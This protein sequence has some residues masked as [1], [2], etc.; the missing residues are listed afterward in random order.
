MTSAK[1]VQK[2][3]HSAFAVSIVS[4]LP[5]I[6]CCLLPTVAALLTL[7]TTV[8]LGAALANDRLY[9]FV[10]GYHVYIL[11]LAVF[12]VVISGVVNLAASRIEIHDHGA[13][14]GH[15]HDA[16]WFDRFS[17]LKIFLLSLGLLAFDVGY[18]LFEENVLGLHHHAN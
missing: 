17:S 7:G 16:S 6:F 4:M 2:L 11:G 14:D 8:G 15:H 1:S 10:D 13:A 18:F 5:H 12:T 3:R 9:R